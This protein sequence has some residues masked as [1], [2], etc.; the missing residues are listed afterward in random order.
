MNPTRR[1]FLSA[2]VLTTAAL[3]LPRFLDA[4][5]TANAVYANAITIDGL[6]GPDMDDG[7]LGAAAVAD[8]RASGLSAVHMTVGEVGGMAPL[9]AFEKIVRSI[10]HWERAID[11]HPEVLARVRSAADIESAKRAGRTGLIYGLQDGVA[12][13]DDLDRLQALH[14]IGIRVIQPTYNR[15]NLLGDGVMEP[16][17]AGLSRTGVEAIERL[18]ALGILV[19]LSHCGRRTSADAIAASKRP[20]AFTH[21]GCAALVDHP[22]HR[23]DAELR[24]VAETGGVIGIFIMPYLA[25]GKQPTAADVIAHL[26]H[27]LKVAGSEHVSIGTDGNLSPTELTPEFIEKFREITRSRKE[28][29]IAAPFET[30]DGYLFANDLNTPRRLETLAELLLARGHGADT[31][32]KVLGGNLLRVFGAAWQPTAG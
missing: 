28:A 29:G 10:A 5:P 21:T 14:Q 9:L 31:V 13:E 15:R 18:N 2:S 25:K 27:A 16:A 3:S 12:F 11:R 1:D 22:R 23:T 17:D 32:G 7:E 24:A 8:V 20:V 6:G 26:E 30:E 19:D 4:A